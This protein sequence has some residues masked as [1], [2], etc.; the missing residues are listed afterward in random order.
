MLLCLRRSYCST[1]LHKPVLYGFDKHYQASVH[2]EGVV[3]EWSKAL[4]LREKINE[5]PKRSQ[6]IPGLGKLK[7]I[8][9]HLALALLINLSEIKS[10]QKI[11]WFGA[12]GSRGTIALRNV[13]P[14]PHFHRVNILPHKNI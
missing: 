5:K 11:F 8:K 1:R 10:F 4:L 2:L 3:S 13:P 9:I 7:N 6:C 14:P 12:A